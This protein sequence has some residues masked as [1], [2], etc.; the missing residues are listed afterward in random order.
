MKIRMSQPEDAAELEQVIAETL[1]TT[2][3]RDYSN[4]CIEANIVSHSA[5]ILIDRAKQGHMYLEPVFTDC[6]PRT[7]TTA[8]L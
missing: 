7:S 1:K 3:S 2:N 8:I 5:E 6:Q 4:E